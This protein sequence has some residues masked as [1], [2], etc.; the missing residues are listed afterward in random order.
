MTDPQR[1]QLLAELAHW[2]MAIDELSD[3]DMIASPTA[4]AALEQYLQKQVRH[5]LTGLVSVLRADGIAT[6]RTVQTH[7]DPQRARQALLDIR[8]RYLQAETLLDFYG[9]AVN[10]RTSPGLASLLQGYDVI[11]TDSMARV[12]D[13]LGIETPPA[14][15]YVD[16][17][18]GAAILRAGIRLWNGGH[19]SPAAAIKLTRHNLL[20]PTALLHE[21][22][23]QVAALTGLNDEIAVTLNQMITPSS[24]RLA[25]LWSSWANELIADVHAFLHAGW[26]PLFALAN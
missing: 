8:Q 3:L 2:Q 20:F 7:P 13:L 14:L 25:D 5:S 6:A 15:V 21:T 16:K 10:S 26:A 17:G 19:L 23:H 22:G 11:A 4:W 1:R 18:L 24:P 12:L 9:D